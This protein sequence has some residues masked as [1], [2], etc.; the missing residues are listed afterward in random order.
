MIGMES[1]NDFAINVGK[2]SLGSYLIRTGKQD[3]GIKYLKQSK[4]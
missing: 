4:N 2:R 1:E 3:E